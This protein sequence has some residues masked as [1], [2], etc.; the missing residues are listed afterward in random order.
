MFSTVCLTLEGGECCPSGASRA[1]HCRYHDARDYGYLSSAWP[2]ICSPCPPTGWGGS[3]DLSFLY[4]QAIEDSLDFAVKNN[5]ILTPASNV[6]AD[7]NGRLIGLH[8]K[9]D[10]AFKLN[11]SLIFPNAWDVDAR[12]TFF[13]TASKHTTAHAATVANTSSGIYPLWVLPQSYQVHPNVFAR[14]SGNWNL[15][16]NT[17]D[18][19]LGANLFLSPKL[20]VR[21][22]GGLKGI[23]IFQL[24]RVKYFEGI[25]IGGAEALPCSATMKSRCYGLGPR[26]GFQG[27]WLFVKNWSFL[28]D[29]AGSLTLGSFRV[30]RDEFDQALPDSRFPIRT[31]S[32]KFRETF[33]V[34]RPNLEALFGFGWDRTYGARGNFSVGFL[35][36]YE[37]QSYW[38]QNAFPQLVSEPI[39][40][41]NFSSRG[42]LYCH[43]LTTTL[44]LGF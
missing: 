22:H 13:Y 39:S 41:L 29:F 33:Y 1:P 4:W 9:W 3:F 16:L 43:G 36:A 18:L 35:A 14:A 44:R 19:E 20:Q 8:F 30:K 2:N 26:L 27:K 17:L 37:V 38:E 10:P 12:W 15:H 5:P 23:S 6:Y 34:Y 31:E 40:F 7:M 25:D 32:S 28:S 21:F 11:F 42:N 24:Y